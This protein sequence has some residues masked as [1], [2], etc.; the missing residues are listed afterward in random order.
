MS[1]VV[2]GGTAVEVT[3]QNWTRGTIQQIAEKQDWKVLHPFYE[4]DSPV[5]WYQDIHPKSAPICMAISHL[6]SATIVHLP[7]S[8]E[9]SPARLLKVRDSSPKSTS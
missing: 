5:S 4:W 9:A 7:I 3:L 6:G 2:I 1:Y 8:K